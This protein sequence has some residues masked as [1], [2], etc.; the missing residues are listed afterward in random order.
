MCSTQLSTFLGLCGFKVL[1]H[2]GGGLNKDVFNIILKMKTP[3]FSH[4]PR[5]KLKFEIERRYEYAPAT[6]WD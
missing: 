6:D 4:S 5:T 3:A 2:F 1:R